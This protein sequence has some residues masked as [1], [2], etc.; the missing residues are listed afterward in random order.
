MEKDGK[1]MSIYKIGTQWT[2]II[3]LYTDIEIPYPRLTILNVFPI[4]SNILSCVE[5]DVWKKSVIQ[6]LILRSCAASAC[7]I[8]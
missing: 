1:T 6:Y 7:I 2:L 8:W 3:I 4:N 5:D